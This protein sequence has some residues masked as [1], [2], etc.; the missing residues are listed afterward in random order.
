MNKVLRLREGSLMLEVLNSLLWRGGENSEEFL[1]GWFRI[2]KKLATTL[3]ET[4]KRFL[5]PDGNGILFCFFLV[6]EI[7]FGKNKKDIV[8]SGK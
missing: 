5:S 3:F 7:R 8:D 2:R 6:K 1:T 4:E